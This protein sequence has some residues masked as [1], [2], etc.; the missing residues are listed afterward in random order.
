MLDRASCRLEEALECVGILLCMLR[1]CAEVRGERESCG[2]TARTRL[3]VH[4]R[5][6]HALSAVI[7][8]DGRMA[9]CVVCVL[10]CAERDSPGVLCDIEGTPVSRSPCRIGSAE[11]TGYSCMTMSRYVSIVDKQG[12]GRLAE[13]D[14]PHESRQRYT[15]SDVRLTYSQ[16]GI[17]S[18]A[19]VFIL[20]GCTTKYHGTYF[21]VQ[22]IQHLNDFLYFEI[23]A[24]AAH[25]HLYKILGKYV[26]SQLYCLLLCT[27]LTGPTCELMS[28]T[29]PALLLALAT[30]N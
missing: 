24:H 23:H 18:I 14:T 30:T 6:Q 16:F 1:L 10:V 21:V 3:Q 12:R 20:T 25:I 2:A 5:A 11:C 4:L 13:T 28:M 19:I 29:G 17:L 8:R 9:R 27:L 7:C 22:F 26:S 15:T